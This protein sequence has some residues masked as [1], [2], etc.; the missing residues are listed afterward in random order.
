MT[1][2]QKVDGIKRDYSNDA[3]RRY[4]AEQRSK[5]FTLHMLGMCNCSKKGTK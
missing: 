4:Y 2:K 1:T 3:K 5:R